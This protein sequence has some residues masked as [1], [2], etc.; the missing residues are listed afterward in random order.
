MKVPKA[1][2]FTDGK[3]LK[4]YYTSKDFGDVRPVDDRDI[5]NRLDRGVKANLVILVIM[6]QW[7]NIHGKKAAAF[8]Q[9]N[10]AD[11]DNTYFGDDTKLIL[12]THIGRYYG[13]PKIK[14][15]PTKLSPT[16][17]YF[18]I[19]IDR[20]GNVYY[21]IIRCANGKTFSSDLL[22]FG[23]KILIN[24]CTI[25][26]DKYFYNVGVSIVNQCIYLLSDDLWNI[27]ADKIVPQHDDSF[28]TSQPSKNKRNLNVQLTQSVILTI[29]EPIDRHD[30]EFV[31]TFTNHL[32]K[33]DSH[34]DKGDDET[35]GDIIRPVLD[36]YYYYTRECLNMCKIYNGI[37][38]LAMLNSLAIISSGP[39][40][41]HMSIPISNRG[42]IYCSME[43]SEAGEVPHLTLNFSCIIINND[44]VYSSPD[45]YIFYK[46]K[47][48]T[49]LN[50]KHWYLNDINMTYYIFD[51]ILI[52]LSNIN[53]CNNTYNGDI[54]V[55]NL[56]VTAPQSIFITKRAE[57]LRTFF[58]DTLNHPTPSKASLPLVYHKINYF[59]TP[60]SVVNL[61]YDTE[62]LIV[63]PS[64]PT[65]WPAGS[66][67]PSAPLPSAPPLNMP[68]Y[69]PAGS[70]M[71]TSPMPSAPPLYDTDIN[72]KR[73]VVSSFVPVQ[74]SQRKQQS[75]EN[76]KKLS[77]P[78]SAPMP[79]A[80]MPSAPMPSAPPLYDTDINPIRSVVSSFV[81]VPVPGTQRSQR[82]QQ[83]AENLKK[84]SRPSSLYS[85]AAVTVA[86]QN[87][88][89]FNYDGLSSNYAGISNI[90]RSQAE[91]LS[92]Y[93][94][95]F[96]S[97]PSSTYEPEIY[98]PSRT[99]QTA[100]KK[101]KA[102]RI[103]RKKK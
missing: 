99:M 68:T 14:E 5:I 48:I 37:L 60:D 95:M 24:K 78:P 32:T 70:P 49:E 77:M 67:M 13:V 101:N 59:P 52:T 83:S 3:E 28:L 35:L 66:P 57:V 30:L 31:Y 16:R 41:T 87:T 43:L 91:D 36:M 1:T 81:P 22:T 100:G 72:P 23:D 34:D 92:R 46:K 97:A 42:N 7:Y 88:V 2:R 58:N 55:K 75:T 8:L 64:V 84:L 44:I 45:E 6:N 15:D 65:Y 40:I 93:R 38:Q 12:S 96:P 54:P 53:L 17:P 10:L 19:N 69:W 39:N 74:G 102:S 80:P 50:R 82:K 71:P 89:A 33:Y 29:S 103:T 90:P 61:A 63:D 9:R 47:N 73:S 18:V 85:T 20:S 26:D 27:N 11:I 98:N 4:M 21:R 62:H 25:T 56:N 51:Y 86:P 79:S 94:D 76:L